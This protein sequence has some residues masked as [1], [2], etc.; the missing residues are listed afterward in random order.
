[1]EGLDF[2]DGCAPKGAV[3]EFRC[4]KEVA[5]NCRLTN[6]V[7]DRYNPVRR[8]IANSY[9]ALYGRY[10]RVDHCNLT[11]KL[12]LGLTLVVI[13]NEES[14][15]HNYHRIDHNRFGYRPV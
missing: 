2:L 4:G 6:C 14:N 15:L 8:D 5:N 13:L 3:V 10:N 12:N 11:G 9:I 7:I 1:M